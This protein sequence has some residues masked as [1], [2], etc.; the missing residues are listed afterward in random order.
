MGADEQQILID[1][2]D[3]GKGVYIEGSDFGIDHTGTDFFNY[4]GCVLD[5]DETTNVGTMTGVPYTMTTGMSFG[6]T[7]GVDENYSVDAISAT[8]GT[9]I[10]I[11]TGEYNRAV[12]NNQSG[13]TICSTPVLGGMIN[14]AAT[15]AQL[16]YEYLNFLLLD[17]G[18]PALPEYVAVTPDPTGA[19]SCELE[20]NNPLLDFS[21]APLA[22]LLEMRLYRNG[23]LIY[24]DSN[25]VI[26]GLASYT[27]TP[28]ESDL[29]N[30]MIVG[31]NS[32]GEG[33]GAVSTTWV[34]EDVPG[35]VEN[36]V[37]MQ[38]SPGVLSGTITWDNPTAGLN[39]GAFNN[40][41]DGYHIERNDGITF[42]L[43][44]IATSF[45]DDTIP[46]AGQY[47]YTVTPYNVVG[48]GGNAT[49]NVVLIADA[50]LL[51]MEDFSGTVPPVGWYIDGLGQTNWSS[52]ATNNAGG[53][54][55]EAMFN[56]YPSF[57]GM[58]RMCTNTFDTSGM[59][60]LILEFKH[61]VNDYAGGY[62]LGVATS[63]DGTTWNDVWSIVPTGAVG[64]ETINVDITTPDVGSATFQMCFY[65]DG[66][67]F[68]IN[69]WYIDDVLLSGDATP[70]DPVEVAP[71]YTELSGN[72]P[73]PFNPETKIDFNL[74]EDQIVEINVYNVKGQIVRQ[75]VKD[76]HLA[77]L[78]SVVWNG[79]DNANKH[80]SSG[81]YFYK[82][83]SGKYTETKKMILMK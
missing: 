73:N 71:I 4:F 76:Q 10:F 59:S 26:G 45:V 33:P 25:P 17:P 19:L 9:N 3:S 8:T 1:Y 70:A 51:L 32:Y 30:Y 75:L 2:L 82:M 42:E 28:A 67:S 80:V 74:H 23:V 77:G 58:S 54:A 20:W 78:H 46:L 60:D 7:S 18:V 72:Y 38:T 31:Y 15:R 37:L 83:K 79:T 64:S 12:S 48:D 40:P 53:S 52:S 22:E 13:L 24:T 16:I 47:C 27:D 39:G 35:A 61:S 65:L 63:S 81:V 29:Y 44:E 36:L 11:S 56:F 43:N 50:G 21:G 14:G 6:F 34:G 68:N 57:I 55:P 62:T 49:S 41:I 5:S 66:D 69:C